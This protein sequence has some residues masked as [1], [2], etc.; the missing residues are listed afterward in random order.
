MSDSH[1]TG[2]SLEHNKSRI[3]REIKTPFKNRTT[4]ILVEKR[5]FNTNTAIEQA[6]NRDLNTHQTVI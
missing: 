2:P 4:I 3:D 6:L 5:A 1:G